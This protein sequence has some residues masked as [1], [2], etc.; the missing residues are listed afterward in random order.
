MMADQVLFVAWIRKTSRSG[1][2]AVAV[3]PSVG[4]GLTLLREW[5]ATQT[6]VPVASAVLRVGIHPDGSRKADNRPCRGG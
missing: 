5:T 3:G 2:V 6:K 4:R 1:W